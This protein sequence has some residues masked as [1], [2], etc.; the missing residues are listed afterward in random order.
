ML[1]QAAV[2]PGN[3]Q[4]LNDILVRATSRGRLRDI[5][6]TRVIDTLQEEDATSR[7]LPWTGVIGVSLILFVLGIILPFWHK[8]ITTHCPCKWRYRGVPTHRS[9]KAA[10]REL[11][12]CEIGLQVQPE[13]TPQQEDLTT[14]DVPTEFVRHGRV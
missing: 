7:S 9:R 12:Q 1:Q 11:N 13:E 10:T 4:K 3:L 2:Q 5:E 8:R 6:V 14:P